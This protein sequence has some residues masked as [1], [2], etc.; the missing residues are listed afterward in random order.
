[1]LRCAGDLAFLFQNYQFAYTNYHQAKRDLS[2]EQA[3][4][5]YAGV[6]VNKISF[7]FFFVRY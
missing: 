7:L 4:A 6:L 5:P 3:P 2:K 1:M